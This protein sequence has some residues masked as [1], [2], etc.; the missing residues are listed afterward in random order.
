MEESKI[1][2]VADREFSPEPIVGLD[3]LAED[4][5]IEGEEDKADNSAS[6]QNP[7]K[8]DDRRLQFKIYVGSRY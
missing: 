7:N 4:M 3:D 1:E 2:Y 6:V 8:N 5:N